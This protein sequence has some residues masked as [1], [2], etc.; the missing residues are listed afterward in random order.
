M[1][2]ENGSPIVLLCWGESSCCSI[3]P[4]Q[5]S[6]SEDEIETWKEINKAWY[7]RRGYWRK[8][9]P[10]YSVTRVDVVK[11]SLLGLKKCPKGRESCEY[12]GMYTERD[13]PAERQELQQTIDSCVPPSGCFYDRHT[14]TVECGYDCTCFT[15]LSRLDDARECPEQ[16]ICTASQNI[17][18]LNTI[19]LM[20]HA[21]INPDLAALNDFIETENLLYS[22]RGVLYLT[23][24]W[25]IWHCPALRDISFRGIV[26]SESWTL[27]M[28][29]LTLPFLVATSLGVVVAAKFFFGW[30][31]A[32][33]VGAFFVGLLSFLLQK[34]YKFG[35]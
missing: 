22:H 12:I 3:L 27:D 23:D 4:V 11:I 25:N 1:S 20:K 15:C 26:I 21:F 9:L 35:E 16:T 31:T 7:T 6:N 34:G 28:C 14:G 5:I 30:D 33:T 13:I 29:Q 18:R 10:G 32:W 24:A 17:L 2:P 8:R 19:H